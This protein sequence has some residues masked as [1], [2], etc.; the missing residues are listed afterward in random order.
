MAILSSKSLGRLAAPLKEIWDSRIHILVLTTFLRFLGIMIMSP[1]SSTV[2]TN[3]FAQ[4]HAGHPIQCVD[5]PNG[6]EPP[7]A[8]KSAHDDIVAWNAGKSF[9][10]NLF[11]SVFLTP[12]LCRMSDYYGRKPF[13][14]YG[15][16]AQ[17]PAQLVML[18]YLWG[19]FP[20]WWY[21]PA[22]IISSA[23]SDGVLTYAYVSDRVSPAHRTLVF[24]L[25]AT[26]FGVAAFLGP[27]PTVVGW[28]KDPL[29]AAAISFILSLVAFVMLVLFVP[30]S[31]SKED[32]EAALEMRKSFTLKSS[33]CQPST[34]V[35]DFWMSFRILFRTDYFSKLSLVVVIL[36][37]L[38]EEVMEV[39]FQYFQEVAGFGT[40]DQANLIVISGAMAIFIQSAGIWG[41][42]SVLRRSN[43]DIL[44]IGISMYVLKMALLT[45]CKTK[46]M[47]YASVACG[48]FV[49]IIFP[50]IAS[51][52]SAYV[53]KEEQ[54]AV[55][56]ALGGAQ[57]LSRGVGPLVFLSIFYFFRHG[58]I[59]FP[60]A[61]FLVCFFFMLFALLVAT[62]IKL[63]P[64]Y[65]D[66]DGREISN[67]QNGDD[68]L[69]TLLP[70]SKEAN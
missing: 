60:G 50:A 34:G 52:K 43:K 59:Y 57:A 16:L 55:Q 3:Y 35:K 37:M 61:P 66:L 44:L 64:L 15:I 18:A 49:F 41:L 68:T 56:G 30:E 42:T 47:A 1:Y 6:Q 11:F 9:I 7:A 2:L 32:K 22:S 10:C 36:Y 39:E 5:L 28:L 69:E 20:L 67:E 48:S 63:P 40:R 51:I 13:L 12:T 53:S 26:P 70:P 45:F 29:I 54:G 19:G 17:L 14:I 27:I 62:T 31:L 8:C 24:G 65:I 33:R 23:F 38:F 4:R 25:T 46:A 21:Y 58:G